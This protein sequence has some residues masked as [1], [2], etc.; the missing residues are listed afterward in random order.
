MAA[1]TF[2]GVTGLSLYC[3]T[4]LIVV[5]GPVGRGAAL[6]LEATGFLVT[7]GVNYP[8]GVHPLPRKVQDR[9]AGYLLDKT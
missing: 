9:A 4:V 2:L 8:P 6:M 7:E 5:Y 1:N 3:K